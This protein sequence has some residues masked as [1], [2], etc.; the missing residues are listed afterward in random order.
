MSKL[1]NK[2]SYVIGTAY[3]LFGF[4]ESACLIYTIIAY[5]MFISDTSPTLDYQIY[6]QI[7]LFVI[8]ALNLFGL[9]VQTYQLRND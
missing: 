9:F 2:N 4:I 3:S 6:L 5:N 7:A 1:Q 8:A